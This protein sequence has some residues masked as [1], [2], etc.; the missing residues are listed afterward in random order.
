[1]ATDEIVVVIENET[2]FHIPSRHRDCIDHL[3][4]ALAVGAENCRPMT[5]ADPDDPEC[6]AARE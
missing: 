6:P 2:L 5:P 1:M 3:L 4:H